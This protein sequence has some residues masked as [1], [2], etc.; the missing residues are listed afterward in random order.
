MGEVVVESKFGL[1]R[2]QLGH[3]PPDPRCLRIIQISSLA[4]LKVI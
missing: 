4:G 3:P 2:F 1:G